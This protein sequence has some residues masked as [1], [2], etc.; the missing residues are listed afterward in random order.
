MG[1][2]NIYL[3]KISGK[4]LRETGLNSEKGRKALVES[5]KILA[6]MHNAGIAHGDFTPA[7]LILSKN[8]V[9]I[10]D[11]GLASLSTD[12]EEKA[13]DVLLMEKSISK[14]DFISF[15]KGYKNYKEWKKVLK[16]VEEIKKR[17]RYQV[18]AEE[19]E[20]IEEE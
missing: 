8:K 20:E 7:N 18:R 3:E 1:K 14:K 15:L 17:G 2:F 9:Y 5:G 10:I 19:K 11:F 6:K 4:R 16:H 13:V 12:I